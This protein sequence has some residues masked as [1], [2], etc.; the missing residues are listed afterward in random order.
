MESLELKNK[1]SALWKRVFHDSEDY[2]SLI[3]NNYFNE[4]YIEYHEDNGKVVSALLGVPYEFSNGVQKLRGLYLCGLATADEYRHQGIMTRLLNTINEKAKEEFDFTF[5]IPS[6]DF[7]ADYYRSKGYYNAIYRIEDRYTD[8]HDFYNDF[9]LSLHSTDERIRKMKMKFYDDIRITSIAGI[10]ELVDIPSVIEYIREMESKRNSYLSLVHSDFDLELVIKENRISNGEIFIAS[11]NAGVITGVIF[12][13]KGEPGRIFVPA[14]Y[15]SDSSSYYRLLDYTKKK[16]ADYSMSVY[17]YPEESERTAL[18]DKVY[19]A[20]N[21]DGGS[22]ESVYGVAERVF[23]AAAGAHL[24]GMVRILN[25][26]SIMQYLVESRNDLKFSILL[27]DYCDSNS[28]DPKE[29]LFMA[30]KGKLEVF[31]DNFEKHDKS[32]LKLSSKEVSKLLFRKKDRSNFIMEAFGV[33]RLSI[34]MQ[35]LLD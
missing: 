18:W 2:V 14:I 28:S 27:K 26:K 13:M 29:T 31:T 10:D 5:L 16:Y 33:P 17:Q 7:N 12:I 9:L 11:D 25:F 23:T 22:L 30:N 6:S 21:P 15:F 32:A 19:G 3:F 35:L 20:G 8:V 24:Y 1:M 34:N 4:K